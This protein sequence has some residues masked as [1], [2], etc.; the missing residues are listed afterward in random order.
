LLFLIE[1]G[2][3]YR[4][5]L[6]KDM[7]RSKKTAEYVRTRHLRQV[8]QFTQTG[9]LSNLPQILQRPSAAMQHQQQRRN[10]LARSIPG[11][12]P[13]TW[14]HPVE[15]S[16]QTE[17]VHKLAKDGQ[18]RVGR[19]RLVGHYGFT[20]WVTMI[21]TNRNANLPSPQGFS[22]IRQKSITDSGIGL[23]L[24]CIGY[25]NTT[26]SCTTGS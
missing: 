22:H 15:C 23:V 4:L 20:S 11:R 16:K 10:E 6:I 19:D 7:M 8:Q 17:R 26:H 1:R 14:Q 3:G 21:G 9:V 18:P 13:R 24:G 2:L 5:E 12:T 25:R